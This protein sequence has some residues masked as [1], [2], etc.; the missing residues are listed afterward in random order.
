MIS[1][2]WGAA[3][4]VGRHRQVNEDSLLAMTPLFL[5]ADGMGGHAAGEVA[6]AL[7]VDVF[8]ALAT[9]EAGITSS[10]VVA[11]L[12]TASEAIGRAAA[13][14]EG[15][16]GMG[17]TAVGLALVRD[18][19]DESLC[20]F[21]VGDSRLYRVAG[22][23]LEQLSTD[24]SYVQELIDRGELAPQD[25]RTHPQR[26]VITRMLGGTEA[27]DP[28]VWLLAAVAGDRYVVCSDGLTGE[29]DD[30]ALAATVTTERDPRV[31]AR[32]LVEQALAGGGRDNISVIV[33]DVLRVDGS[34]DGADT[35]PRVAEVMAEEIT[36]PREGRAADVAAPEPRAGADL[37]SDVPW[38]I[39]DE[40][41][42]APPAEPVAMINEVPL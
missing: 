22:G 10:D 18:G 1:L 12:R 17:T 23:R 7:T 19:E 9:I 27:V 15:R 3:T 31:A 36:R 11:A 37:L 24:H 25:A 2:D 34:T 32:T 28:D 5:V 29:V 8:A 33:V 21:N 35:A 42:A 38:T 40:A 4:D 6:S 20:G 16:T 39:V 14:S 41:S 13:A 30:Q 26:N